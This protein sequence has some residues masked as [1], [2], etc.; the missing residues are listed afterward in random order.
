MA[1]QRYN[2][3]KALDM[4]I[5]KMDRVNKT[6]CRN[7]SDRL[8]KKASQL[9][10]NAKAVTIGV[11]VVAKDVIMLLGV[12]LVTPVKLEIQ[13]IRAILPGAFHNWNEKLD[14][15]PIWL[16]QI[17]LIAVDILG[18]G[19]STGGVVLG[20]L[21]GS[22]WNVAI[23]KSLYDFSSPIQLKPLQAKPIP[24]RVNKNP[25]H[26]V[27]GHAVIVRPPKLTPAPLFLNLAAPLVQVPPQPTAPAAQQIPIA[28]ANPAS[29]Q[30]KL[31]AWSP[32]ST[33]ASPGAATANPASAKPKLPAWPPG[34][35]S[36]SPV[37]NPPMAKQ[38]L[39]AWPPTS[40]GATP[41]LANSASEK[42]KPSARLPVAAT[43]KVSTAEPRRNL[44]SVPPA[45]PPGKAP[46]AQNQQVKSPD[47]STVPA[48]QPGGPLATTPKQ[49]IPV[50][51][52]KPDDSPAA[53]QK[54]LPSPKR[55][56][57]ALS[58][59]FS[60]QDSDDETEDGAAEAQRKKETR[61]WLGRQDSMP[62]GLRARPTSSSQSQTPEQP[63]SP[64]KPDD[65]SMV[66][67]VSMPSGGRVRPPFH[68][69][70]PAPA[71]PKSPIQSLDLSLKASNLRTTRQEGE[72][73]P[74]SKKEDELKRQAEEEK[75]A[76]MAADPLVNSQVLAKA[77]QASQQAA[78]R[79]AQGSLRQSQD[80]SGISEW[81]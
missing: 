73:T 7:A 49:S 36:T 3:V 51:I 25:G 70:S 59:D 52:I 64:I 72:K 61:Q 56:V 12:I 9:K 8:S 32:G 34:P 24:P 19:A 39:P 10:L 14:R 76:K 21:K 43:P 63:A 29:A 17:A 41:G 33:S 57:L 30:P 20:V 66:M 67:Q 69:P 62:S 6:P 44:P 78:Q 53:A 65:V 13:I 18:V 45:T 35:T 77:Q 46:V 15:L 75:R 37:A 22:E 26:A 27:P 16:D 11:Y 2:Y 48:P 42:P 81:D 50:V 58:D 79:T 5:T 31:P 28:V 71:Q 23:Q 60:A 38:K 68:P 74:R 47:A 40:P 1:I 54:T 4:L 55:T 80:S